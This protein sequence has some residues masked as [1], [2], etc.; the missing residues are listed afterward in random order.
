MSALGI[1]ICML[2]IFRNLRLV[3]SEAVHLLRLL[4]LNGLLLRGRW[5]NP[6]LSIS[7]DLEGMLIGDL[8]GDVLLF[9]SWDIA[10]DFV[11]LLVLLHIESSAELPLPLLSLLVC[12]MA[13][14]PIQLT[15][16]IIKLTEE[17]DE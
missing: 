16:D 5:F 10:L 8:D 3:Q 13:S 7:G 2:L 4:L 17:R 9:K 1:A 12:G 14:L 11:A 15:E 6:L